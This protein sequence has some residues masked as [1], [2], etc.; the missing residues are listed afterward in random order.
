MRCYHYTVYLKKYFTHHKQ[1]FSKNSYI[2]FSILNNEIFCMLRPIKYLFI[3]GI[4]KV[5]MKSLLIEFHTIL[6]VFQ[7]L[8]VH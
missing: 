1:A 2:V 5:N 4:V 7:E 6:F 8:L 3:P